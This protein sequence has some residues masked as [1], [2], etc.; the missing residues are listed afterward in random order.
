MGM[1]VMVLASIT[2]VVTLSLHAATAQV[3]TTPSFEAASIKVNN[4]GDVRTSMR[5]LPGGHV[6]ARN[7]T[8]K[9]LIQT[10]F[11]LQDFQIIGGPKWLASARFDVITRGPDRQITQ[12]DL[13]AM[14]QGLL[15]DRFRLTTHRATREFS[16]YALR[17][18]RRDGRLGSAVRPADDCYIGRGAPSPAAQP[19]DTTRG[20]CGFTERAGDMTARGVD[21]ASLAIELTEY[22]DRPVVDQ[23][24]LRG[25]FNLSLKWSPEGTASDSNLPSIF[26]AVREQL[27][28]KLESTT[29]PVDVLVIDR[30]EMPTED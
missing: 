30:A 13:R 28:L 1:R 11:A 6:D 26:T 25:N 19:G 29:G 15:A 21:M 22:T 3:A 16:I 12:A 2:A 10:A 7:R 9:L 14:L 24:N 23:T 5:L 18:D 17:M 8:L 4:S 20:V 27:G